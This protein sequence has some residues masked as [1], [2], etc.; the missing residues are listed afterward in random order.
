MNGPDNKYLNA[1]PTVWLC[2][3][4]NPSISYL[5]RKEIL[6]EGASDSLYLAI[7]ESAE[8][9]RI[10]KKDVTILGSEK[11]FD[12]FYTGAMW[13]FAEAVERGLDNRTAAIHRTADFI[14]SAGQTESGGFSLNW[15]PR[16]EVA[17]RTGDM[18]RYLLRAG[19]N[20]ER[21]E[22]GISWIREHQRHDG[23]WLHCP[24][25]G[26]CDQ[27][28]LVFINRPGSGLKREM[29]TRVTSCFYATIACSMALIEF[30]QRAGSASHDGQIRKA[31]EFF[32]KRSLYK[33]SGNEP[34]RP[35]GTWNRDFRLLGYPVLS[36]YDVLYGLLFVAK[37]GCI[38]DRRTG[39]AFN[40]IM[41]KQND[42]GTWNLENAQTGMLYGNEAGHHVG[43]K[44]K[45]VTLQVLRLL[46]YS[47]TNTATG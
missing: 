45:W 44:S 11:N 14:V 19:Y 30:R 12:L 21:I 29:D 36:Q 16:I 10:M 26:M 38:A 28:R 32:L 17:C 46:K 40:L 35:K 3:N 27:L 15:N 42:D 25:A 41:S 43:K 20:D 6:E 5:T 13:C 18:I 4:S 33:D 7:A 37:A 39:D 8:M 47:G 23:G 24:I 22:R 34:I 2:D 1:N 31:A 9:R